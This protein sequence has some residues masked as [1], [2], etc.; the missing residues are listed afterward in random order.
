MRLRGDSHFQII[1][2]PAPGTI[3]ECGIRTV[4]PP[5]DNKQVRRAFNY[6][7]DRPRM[8]ATLFQDTAQARCLPW[9][10]VAPGYDAVRN[11]AYSFDLDKATAMRK[12]AGATDLEMDYFF[13]NTDAHIFEFAQIYQAD[14]AKIG[15][16]MTL[17][18]VERPVWSAHVRAGNFKGFWSTSDSSAHLSPSTFLSISPGWMPANNF[19]SFTT[20]VYTQFVNTASSAVTSVQQRMRSHS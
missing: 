12:A 19:S 16:T 3:Y 5:F 2:H 9:D 18:R 4:D 17:N 13:P 20:D 7:F 14:L 6:A 11:A 1:A 8:A 15:V 10:P